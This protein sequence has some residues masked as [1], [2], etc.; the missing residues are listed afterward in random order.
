VHL[1]LIVLTHVLATISKQEFAIAML[2]SIFKLA[3][4]LITSRFKSYRA[5][6]IKLASFVEFSLVCLLL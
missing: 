1:V 5:L 3:L 6:T 4:V 2:H